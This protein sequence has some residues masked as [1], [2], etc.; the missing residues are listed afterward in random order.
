MKKI[1]FCFFII[2]IY[3]CSKNNFSSSEVS[4]ENLLKEKQQIINTDKFLEWV[5]KSRKYFTKQ[6]NQLSFF[7]EVLKTENN[8][9][10]ISII[11]FIISD[12]YWTTDDTKT[13]SLIY[14][15][16]VKKEDFLIKYK[17]MPIGYTICLRIIGSN[18]DFVNK[19]KMYKI[20][21]NDFK[22]YIDLP[23]TLYEFSKFY[24]NNMDIKNSITCLEKIIEMSR[25][26]KNIEENIN[27]TEIQKEINFYYS[28]KLWIYKDIKEL[29]RKIEIAVKEKNN[30]SL[31]Q[32]ASKFDFNIILFQKNI[33]KHWSL[34]ELAIEKRFNDN[35]I[36]AD[37]LE[38]ISNSEEAYLKTENWDFPQMT[39]W[40]FY[41]KKIKYPYDNKI[42]G[43]WEWKGIYFGDLF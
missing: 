20:L 37:K 8:P 18:D 12:I 3:S 17:N 39:T 30:E 27:L 41:F 19:E 16:K 35:I 21:L 10:N 11:N 28:K 5:D 2:L 6:E 25:K 40:Y 32:Y 4:K 23:Y 14:M 42:D 29:I 33:K 9:T 38:N 7:K 36:F 15:K 13:D 31:L 34:K 43:G 22:D 26:Y 24:K 1:V